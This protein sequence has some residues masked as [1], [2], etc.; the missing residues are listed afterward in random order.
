MPSQK[1]LFLHRSAPSQEPKASQQQPSPAQMQEMYAAFNAWKEKFKANIVDMG[2]KLKPGGKVVTASGVTDGPFV[3]A[4]EIVGGFMIVTAESW[5]RAIEVAKEM[6]MLMP[7]RAHRDP[8]DG[9]RLSD[10]PEPRGRPGPAAAPGLVEHFFRHE[11]GRLVAML[12]RMVGV[13]HVE[14]VEDAVQA[15]LMSALTAWTAKGLPDD[16]GALAVPGGPQPPHRGAAAGSR[17][18]PDPRAGTPHD[19]AE[20]GGCPRRHRI[21]PGEVRDDLLRMLFVCCDDAIPRGIAAG[22]GAEDAVRLQHRGDRAAAVH[23]RGER[24]QAP[25]ARA[26]PAAR[27]AARPR[28]AAARDAAVAAAERARG[29]LPALQRG[30]PLRARGTGDP[31]RAVRRGHPAGHAPGGAPGGRG[32]GDLCPARAHAPPCGQAGRA[33]RRDGRPAAARGAGPV[34]FGIANR[35]S[36]GRSGWRGPPAEKCSHASMPKP[37]SPPSIAL[38]PRLERPA[39]KRSPTCTPCWSASPRR[40]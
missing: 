32:P 11:Y 16:P 9:G 29:A 27:G 2:D 25:G 6:P 19:L 26:R 3:E 14:V 12:T 35:S 7:G 24:A 33:P 20:E 1:Y 37:A 5:E 10:D 28:D 15:A 22:P 23:L 38:R 17:S 13:R 34:A 36:L 8:G 4:K 21:S 40:R 31:P 39:G 30:L 18:A